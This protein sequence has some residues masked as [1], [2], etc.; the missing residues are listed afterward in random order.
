MHIYLRTAVALL[1]V[2][3]VGACT[4][5][6]EEGSPTPSP[7]VTQTAEPVR[8]VSPT[9][10]AL[11]DEPPATRGPVA[12]DCVNGWK[13]PAEDSA[14]F[15]KPLEVIRRETGVEGELVV[16]DMRSFAGPESPP[17]DKGYL[18]EV[19]R[20]Y[21]KAFAPDD[22]SFQARFLVESRTFG[23]GLV[24]VAPYD[25][26]GFRSPDWVGFQFDSGDPEPK[27]YEGLPGLWAGIPYDFVQGGAGLEIP[28]LP[29]QV[30]GCLDAT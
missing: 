30:A 16:V 19:E 1:L 12:P 25:S 17:S 8:P 26:N 20:W 23:E 15:A 18:V 28:G 5:G 13:T 6:D 14:R 24:A 4:A 9:P 3:V 2:L 11:P 22:L 21:V 7:P 27:F 10:P 29:D